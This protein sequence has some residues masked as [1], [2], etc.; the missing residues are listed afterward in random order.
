MRYGIAIL[1][2]AFF[3]IIGTVVLVGR[4]NGN[5]GGA[6]AR[7]T[8]LAEYADKDSASLT[9]TQQ[10]RLVGEDQRSAIRVT[11]TRSTRTV[12]LLAGYAER[13]ERKAEFP[14]SPEAFA[15]FTRSLDSLNFGKE[16]TVKQAD[17]RSVC[18]QGNR[19][20][21]RLADNSKEIMRTWSDNCLNGDGPFGGGNTAPLI[22]QLFKAQITDYNKFIIGVVL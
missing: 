7:I 22:A 14:N 5:G 4:D 15:T 11:V 16:R 13:V 1:L 3:A 20:V 9:W 2:I 10:G 6:T 8:K 18:P 19:F 12:E 21:Y 17:E